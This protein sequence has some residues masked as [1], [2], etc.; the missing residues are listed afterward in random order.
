M[1]IH[2][3]DGGLGTDVHLK[4]VR[5]SSALNGWRDHRQCEIVTVALAIARDISENCLLCKRD[6]ESRMLCQGRFCTLP[7]ELYT[8]VNYRTLDDPRSVLVAYPGS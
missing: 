7:W 6:T 4:H 1:F 2:I 3:G 8:H 5:C